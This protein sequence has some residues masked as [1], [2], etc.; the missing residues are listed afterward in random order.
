MINLKSPETNTSVFEMYRLK[1][2]LIV[3]LLNSKC[4]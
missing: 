2:K 3:Y 4:Q 1:Y